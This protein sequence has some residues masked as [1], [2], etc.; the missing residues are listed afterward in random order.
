MA[1]EEYK[2]VFSKNLKTYM[3]LNGKNQMD[4]MN[5]LHLS[6][7]TVSNW[8]TGTK[9]PRMDKVQMLADYFH[10]NKSDLIEQKESPI[11]SDVYDD[12]VLKLARSIQKFHEPA[13][14]LIDNYE[15]LSDHNKK[16]VVDYSDTLLK[17]QKMEEEQ[18]LIPQA[19]HER[20][21][22]TVT[23]EMVKHDDDIMNDPDF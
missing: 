19:A 18:Y 1:D 12:K 15:Q 9:L 13:K 10:I 16:K 11:S 14:K 3:K 17:I 8:C 23:A 7:S 2:K 20:T 4:L 6:S 21:D 22:T 5:D